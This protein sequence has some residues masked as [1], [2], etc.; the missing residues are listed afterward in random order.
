MLFSY[1]SCR[2][3]FNFYSYLS[4][5]VYILY[6]SYCHF[7][8]SFYFIAFC[9][10]FLYWAQGPSKLKFRP[11]PNPFAGLVAQLIQAQAKGTFGRL[12]DQAKTDQRWAHYWLSHCPTHQP[13]LLLSLTGCMAYTITRWPFLSLLPFHAGFTH[14][15]SVLP[16][17]SHAI[18]CHPISLPLSFLTSPPRACSWQPSM[19]QS[20]V[21]CDRIN[22]TNNNIPVNMSCSRKISLSLSCVN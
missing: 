19:T 8:F 17:T 11:I 3:I 21:H 16:A 5:F 20:N 9:L 15:L 12:L 7:Y 13:R 10:P 14:Q 1:F 2:V 18:L 4:C 22:T 6:I